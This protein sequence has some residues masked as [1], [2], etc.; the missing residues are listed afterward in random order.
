MNNRQK[1]KHFKKLYEAS[2]YNVKELIFPSTTRKIVRVKAKQTIS[3]SVTSELSAEVE[4]DF[5]IACKLTMR[6]LA[7]EISKYAKCT[8]EPSEIPYHVNLVAE[9]DV[10]NMQQEEEK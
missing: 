1:A 10:I 7:K 4:S 8:I 5:S 6:E 9:I 3:E 2:R